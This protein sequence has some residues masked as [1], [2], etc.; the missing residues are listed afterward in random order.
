MTQ[1]Q[2]TSH[3]TS[4]DQNSVDDLLAISEGMKVYISSENDAVLD[5]V[6]ERI[7]NKPTLMQKIFPGKLGRL[8]DKIALSQLETAFKD[9]R[10]LLDAFVAT[11]LE[12]A[13]RRGDA[14][15]VVT[16]VDLQAKL[17][18]FATR[19]MDDLTRTLIKSK[20]EFYANSAAHWRSLEDYKDVPP[21]YEEARQSS[22]R[23][24][25]AFLDWVETVRQK[26]T[27]ALSAKVA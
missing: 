2:T 8:Q 9:R 14:L 27:D 22:T 17:A 3:Q 7:N 12:I 13:R 1:L 6:L 15:V 20:E 10:A 26:F 4:H 19:K 25:R 11:Q 23:E 18:A 16:S 24:I 21:L 5:S